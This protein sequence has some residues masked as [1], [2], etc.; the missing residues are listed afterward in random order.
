MQ[1]LDVWFVLG[2]LAYLGVIA[3]MWRFWHP[4]DPLGRDGRPRRR[5]AGRPLPERPFLLDGEPMLLQAPASLYASRDRT[6]FVGGAGMI[7]GGGWLGGFRPNRP[8][9]AFEHAG[10]LWLTDRRLVF[11]AAGHALSLPL[12]GVLQ[13][14]DDGHWLTVWSVG[15][16]PVRRWRVADATTW[17]ERIAAQASQPTAA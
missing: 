17:R 1:H 11:L 4:A 12:S 3:L 15:D 6:Q 14:Q 7:A 8:G 9:Y 10:T 16:E 13:V 5:P 2:A